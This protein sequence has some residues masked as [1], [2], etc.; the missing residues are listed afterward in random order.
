M[1]TDA[2]T[3]RPEPPAPRQ[4]VARVLALAA[5]LAWTGVVIATCVAKYR[6]FLYTDF[7]LAIF[8]QATFGMLRGQWF[9]SVRGM[10]W[11][12]DHS[13]LVLVLLAPL[14]AL[15][16]SPLLLPCVQALALAAGAWPLFLYARR[17]L[18]DET[19]AAAF[20]AIWVLQPALGYL[21]TFEFHP[22]TIATPALLGV[23]AALAE[24]RYRTAFACAL[25][26]ALA[27]EDVALPL[28]VLGALAAFDTR[29][30]TRRTGAAVIG[31]A[32]GSLLFSF[33]WLKPHLAHGEAAYA[34]MYAAWGHSPGGVLAGLLRHPLAALQ[35]FW[36]TPGNPADGALKRAFWGDL[37]RPLAFLPWLG[38]LT[39]LPALPVFAEHLLSFRPEQHA[40]VFQYTALSL[41]FVALAAVDGAAWLARRLNRAAPQRTGRRIALWTLVV[42]LACQWSGGPWTIDPARAAFPPTERAWPDAGDVAR[43]RWRAAFQRAL[44]AHGEIITDFPSLSSLSMRDSLHSLHHVAAGRYTFSTLA[45]PAPVAPTGMLADLSA[46]AASG[47]IDRAGLARVRDYARTHGLRIVDAAG[48]LVRLAATPRDTLAWLV[49]ADSAGTPVR[50]DGALECLGGAVPQPDIQPGDRLAIV[51]R[52]RRIATLPGLAQVQWAVTDARGRTL[53]DEPRLLGGGW[54]DPGMWAEAT[55]FA[56]RTTWIAP[57]TLAPGTYTLAFSVSW[58]NG[59]DER[60]AIPE[61]THAL[62]AEGRVEVGRFRVT[63]R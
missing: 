61:I 17:R 16:R 20:A 26:A 55:S 49:A 8:S 4:P 58:R 51:T 28:L 3:T 41:P 18:G 14:A 59:D 46:L 6:N 45:Y 27:R 38:A 35:A 15:V 31:L 29:R 19:A 63:K 34:A 25:L 10:A 50:F 1:Q 54:T 56:V 52:W 7:D 22:E 2:S 48:D 47:E 36:S 23:V 37:T 42:A 40:I 53:E 9:S 21:A 12:G 57:A 32:L 30:A 11:L 62:D 44:P 24:K 13:S 33:L 39:L 60:D 43:A 5:V